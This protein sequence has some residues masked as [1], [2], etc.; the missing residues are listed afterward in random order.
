MV[1]FGDQ[2][3][4]VL[5]TYVGRAGCDLGGILI[6][7]GQLQLFEGGRVERTLYTRPAC[8]GKPSGPIE[9]ERISG[10]FE[11]ADARLIVTRELASGR[12]D[13]WE[14]ER[15]G[16]AGELRGGESHYFYPNA[17]FVADV[18]YRRDK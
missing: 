2:P 3:L 7:G 17:L 18:T 8:D 13:T 12:V 16:E 15:T 11:L 14:Y 9:V 6:L 4:P 1:R 10:R 5:R